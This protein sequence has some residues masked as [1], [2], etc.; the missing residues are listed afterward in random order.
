ML[1]V[2]FLYKAVNYLALQLGQS[3]VFYN[4][5]LLVGGGL[6]RKAVSLCFET[7]PQLDGEFDRRCADFLI[8]PIGEQGIELQ[9]VQTALG[10]HRAAALDHRDKLF[11][12]I[13]VREHNGFAAERAALGAANVEH[14]G[15]L[16]DVCQRH[17]SIC[18]EA[19]AEACAIQ[20]QWHGKLP[21]HGRNALQLVSRVKRAVFGRMGD[22]HHAR[23]HHVVMACVRVEGL[24]ILAQIVRIQ[25][26]V[27]MR[28]GQHLVSGG[29]DGAGFMRVH[30]PAGRRHNTL[31]RTE[32]RVN[33]DHVGL[34]AAGQEIHLSVRA[35]RR[36]FD[37]FCRRSGKFIVAVA[38]NRLHIRLCQML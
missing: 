3:A 33:D 1:R 7:V 8:Q 25:L 5:E 21:A 24:H 16:C 38:G 34:R 37:L 32:Q 29:L 31:I 30:M 36:R 6:E 9:R 23:E 20:K 27:L 11:R 10:D 13:S 2:I 28:N 17:I 19:V 22:V 4:D 18:R 12:H 14:I 26:A 15:E 35:V